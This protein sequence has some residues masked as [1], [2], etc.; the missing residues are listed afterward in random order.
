MSCSQK[1]KNEC[2]PPDCKWVDKTRKYCRVSKNK[3]KKKPQ[4]KPRSRSKTRSRSSKQKTSK[5]KSVC[6]PSE[7]R[8][9]RIPKNIKSKT[10]KCKQFSVYD[11]ITNKCVLRTSKAGTIQEVKNLYYPHKVPCDD[12]HGPIQKNNN[13]WFNASIVSLFMSDL[14]SKFTLPLR[15]RMI[16]GIDKRG[17]PIK[18]KNL[19]RAL[20]NLNE[21]LELIE[22]GK[23][24]KTNDIVK[25]LNAGGFETE[26]G[27]F[28]TPNV[29]I[30]ELYSL[31][32]YQNK[33]AENTLFPMAENGEKLSVALT[34][35]IQQM[36]G[37]AAKVDFNVTPE[38]Y[39]INIP[40]VFMGHFN[41]E[42]TFSIFGKKYK[43]DSIIMHSLSENHWGCAFTCNDKGYFHD[44]FATPSVKKVNWLSNLNKKGNDAKIKLPGSSYEFRLDQS[45]CFLFY[46]RV[47]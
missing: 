27:D 15:H 4:S 16:H 45:N 47:N 33:S 40:G 21:R 1:P 22:E 42:K 8:I 13:C 41:K 10:K 26:E 25:L 3:T 18:S 46:Y 35:Q 14:G 7:T 12:L 5:S 29:F 11:E 38:Q 23:H 9:L 2:L 28:G 32:D 24:M 36:L 34:S 39:I 19:K 43:L 17:F 6:T 31:Y 30:G 44:G 37:Q 20:K